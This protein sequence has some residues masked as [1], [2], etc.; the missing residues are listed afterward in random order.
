MRAGETESVGE[1]PRTGKA[2]GDS[3]RQA[4]T[5]RRAAASGRAPPA[6]R[7]GWW[8]LRTPVW[9]GRHTPGT[10]RPACRPHA[11]GAPSRAARLPVVLAHAG[12]QPRR[13]KRGRAPRSG[14]RPRRGRGV[15]YRAARK[16]TTWSARLAGGRRH[17]LVRGRRQEAAAR[18]FGR[19]GAAGAGGD[20]PR[21]G[22]RRPQQDKWRRGRGRG[23]P[24]S[25]VCSEVGGCSSWPGT[26]KKNGKYNFLEKKSETKSY[27]F[28]RKRRPGKRVTREGPALHSEPSSGRRLHGVRRAGRMGAQPPSAG[29]RLRRPPPR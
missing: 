12:S 4:E 27:F 11:P 26:K 13:E 9:R 21:H 7:Q 14:R 5:C 25:S 8:T 3:P 1:K 28:E 20:T 17:R 24:A 2:G 16:S 15:S 18:S 29:R 19:A 6:A 22:W 23:R 10:R